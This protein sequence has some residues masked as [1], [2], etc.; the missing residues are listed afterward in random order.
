MSEAMQTEDW[1]QTERENMLIRQLQARGI[2]DESVLRA[3]RAVPRHKFVPEALRDK[4]YRDSPLPIGDDQTI[5][6]PFIVAYMTQLLHLT[7]AEHVLE[8]G[9]GSGYQTAILSLLCQQVYS[10]ERLRRLA[11]T[12]ALR[13]DCLHYD[14]IDIHVGDGS[15]GLPD[16]APFDAILV[17]A[18]A[19][20]SPGP[21]KAQLSPFGGR[22][23]VPVGDSRGQFLELT[24]REGEHWYVK[25]VMAVKFV[26]LIGRF[27]FDDDLD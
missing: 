23:V 19:P 14:N 27:G 8:I 26:P 9:T 18:A 4:A 7:G 12:A 16:M 2:Q 25:R 17:A 20:C 1:F 21:L 11:R 10:M 15:Q 22:L 13:L 3:I 5:S 6:Q 24:V